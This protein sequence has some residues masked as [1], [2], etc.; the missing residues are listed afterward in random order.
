MKKLLVLLLLPLCFACSNDDVIDAGLIG[1]WKLIKIGSG[2]ASGTL[3]WEDVQDGHILQFNEN[4]SYK[5]DEFTVCQNKGMN[6]GFYTT[7]KNTVVGEMENIVYITIE[8]CPGEPDNVYAR[9]FFY[10]FDNEDLILMAREPSCIEGCEYVYER[11][12]Q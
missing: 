11:I 5:S 9:S 1:K 12:K 6:S 4:L 8:N 7:E 10:K 3:H 2:D